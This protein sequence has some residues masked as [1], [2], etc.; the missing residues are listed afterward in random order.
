MPHFACGCD[1]STFGLHERALAGPDD[2][3][4]WQVVDH[5]PLTR[6]AKDAM[7]GDDHRHVR[8]QVAARSG[9]SKTLSFCAVFLWVG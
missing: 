2:F 9:E 3:G 8:E 1:R 7:D 6:K 4:L 5:A